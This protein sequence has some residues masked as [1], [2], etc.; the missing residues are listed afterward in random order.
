G[1]SDSGNTSRIMIARNLFYNCSHGLLCK[2]GNFYV[3]MNNTFVDMKESVLN[4]GEPLRNVAGGAGAIFSGNIVSNTPLVFENFTNSTMQLLVDH[5]L[6][7]T[8]W[9]GDGNIVGAPTFI[10]GNPW[11]NSFATFTNDFQLQNNSPGI[12]VGPNGLDMGAFVPA[13]ASISGEPSS[14]TTNTTAT[15]TIAGPGIVGYQWRT[16]NGPWSSFATLTNAFSYTTNLFGNAVPVT[17]TN[18]APATYTVY[19]VGMNSAGV[20]QDTNSPTISKTWTIVANTISMPRIT[21]IGVNG[22]TLTIAATNGA[23]NG[24]WTLLESTNV[25]LPLSQWQTN[26]NGVF[27]GSGNISTNFPNAATNSQKF[28]I[29]KQ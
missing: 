1:G 11:T 8:N 10:N 22:T 27:D 29:L 23:A 2:E 14:P 4:F 3:I 24:N 7:P 21:D 5:C 17:L 26:M 28:Y 12:G 9:P 15:L 6:L 19:V 13:G 20:W 25:A 16:N 18:L